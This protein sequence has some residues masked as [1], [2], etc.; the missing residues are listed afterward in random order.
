MISDGMVLNTLSGRFLG[1]MIL[2]VMIAEVLFFVPSMTRFRSDYLQN[3]IEMAQLAALALLATPPDGEIAPDLKS[4]ILATADV[5]NVVLRRDDV[6]ELMFE[7]PVPDMVQETFDLRDASRL[8]LV[9]DTLRVF[10][11]DQDRIIRVIGRSNQG[12]QSEIE[13]TL[14]EWPLRQAM[15]EHGRRILLVS[16]VVSLATAAMLFFAVQRLIVRP[17]GRVVE[18]M[19]AYRDDPMDASRI[20]APVSGARELRE[21]ET[22]LY[23]LEV[24]LSAALRQKERLAE[25]G[26]AVAKISHDLRNMLTTAQLLTDRIEASNDPAVRRTAPKLVGSLARAISLCERTLTFGKAEELPAEPADL[27]LAPLVAEVLENEQAGA[28]PCV[29]LAAEVPEGLQVRADPDQLFRVLT[30][31]VRNAS[32]AIEAAGRPGSITVTAAGVA[33]WSEIR[34]RDTGPGLPQKA[35]DNLFRPFRGGVRQG[36][37]GL[38]LVIAADLVRGHGGTLELEETGPRGS[39]FRI[40]LP[41]PGAQRRAG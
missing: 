41:A 38:G 21:A 8:T 29:S 36:G 2:F 27:P 30:N 34:V 13:V 26:A 22:A 11:A 15:V 33:G 5:I 4:E 31:L 25:L 37:A 20:I 6:R 35:R 17:I 3:R 19:T 40:T 16:L 7:A 24:Q 23:E 1:L 10:V 14:H 28:A 32:Q 12:A 18:H 39:T 9:R